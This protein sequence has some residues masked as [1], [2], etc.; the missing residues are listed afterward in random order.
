M[1]HYSV[2]LQR[3]PEVCCGGPEGAPE[4]LQGQAADRGSPRPSRRA[5]AGPSRACLRPPPGDLFSLGEFGLQSQSIELYYSSLSL[6]DRLMMHHEVLG[7]AHSQ[8]QRTVPRAAEA[9][10]DHAHSRWQQT[11]SNAARASKCSTCSPMQRAL[12]RASHAHGWQKLTTHTP[13]S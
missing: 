8:V 13:R 2:S 6:Q 7:E 11:H 3:P 10:K 9:P 4:A 5:N 1:K 12:P